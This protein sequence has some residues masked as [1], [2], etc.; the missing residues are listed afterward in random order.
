VEDPGIIHNFSPTVLT[1]WSVST[2]MPNMNTVTFSPIRVERVASDSLRLQWRDGSESTL[3][4]EALRLNC[5]CA[6]C[7]EKMGDSSH[8][9]PLTPSKPTLLRV[10]ES[11]REEEVRLEKIWPVGNY[12]IGVQWGDGHKTGIYT[13]KY[14]H[15]L[16]FKG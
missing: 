7:K 14:L 2:I 15:E 1:L 4:S 12:A 9:T 5:P 16:S 11:S 13:F 3:S 6:E 10:I 8:Q